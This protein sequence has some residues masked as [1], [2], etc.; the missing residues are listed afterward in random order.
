[1]A[2]QESGRQAAIV[3]AVKG[4]CEGGRVTARNTLGT[5]RMVD[6]PMGELLPRIC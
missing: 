4:T 3:G 1:M 6:L 2:E 5:A